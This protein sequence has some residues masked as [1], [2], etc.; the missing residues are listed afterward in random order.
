M[1]TPIACL[2]ALALAT[3]CG[4]SAPQARRSAAPSDIQTV[5]SV[6][7][8]PAELQPPKTLTD[9][10]PALKTTTDILQAD[11][12]PPPTPHAEAARAALPFA[13]A[14]SLDPVDGMKVSIG[15]HTPTFDYNGH[16]Y[17]FSSEADKRAFASNPDAYTKSH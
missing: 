7:P 10:G 9:E 13:P 3:A 16:I 8:A 5:D 15:A 14:I 6:P 12:P 1:K 11:A 17:Y 4:R 2:M